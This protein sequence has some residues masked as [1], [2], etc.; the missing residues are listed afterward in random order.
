MH[1]GKHIKC[2]IL[3]RRTT[4]AK[5][6]FRIEQAGCFGYFTGRIFNSLAFIEHHI[7]EVYA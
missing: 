1:L 7:V 5:T 2:I 3:K 4:H 6:M